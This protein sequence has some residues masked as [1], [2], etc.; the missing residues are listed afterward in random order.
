MTWKLVTVFPGLWELQCLGL[1]WALGIIQPAVWAGCFPNT[2]VAWAETEGI[3][4]DVW[5]SSLNCRSYLSFPKSQSHVDLAHE[6]RSAQ[7]RYTL[8]WKVLPNRKLGKSAVQRWCCF[9]ACILLLFF[10]AYKAAD[11][12]LVPF[13]GITFIT[14]SLSWANPSAL[15]IFTTIHILSPSLLLSLCFLLP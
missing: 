8:T 15:S 12:F 4:V 13:P 7:H 5:K 1:V 14:T 11:V 6:D 3:S 9:M 2:S 10:L